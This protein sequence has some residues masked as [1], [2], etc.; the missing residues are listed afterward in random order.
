MLWDFQDEQ[1]VLDGCEGDPA[2]IAR[3]LLDLFDRWPPPGGAWFVVYLLFNPAD[4]HRLWFSSAGAGCEVCDQL[5]KTYRRET[6]LLS[7]CSLG[8]SAAFAWQF[9]LLP[10]AKASVLELRHV[11]RAHAAPATVEVVFRP[12]EHGVAPGAL[13]VVTRSQPL[14]GDG[15][16][17][18][19]VAEAASPLIY[20]AHHVDRFQRGLRW[21]RP[22][23]YLTERWN[24]FRVGPHPAC[25]F[26]CEP[27]A[28]VWT[29]S[30]LAREGRWRV[31]RAG[32]GGRATVDEEQSLGDLLLRDEAVGVCV[33]G[34]A[35]SPP[36]TFGEQ[37]K[38]NFVPVYDLA[39]VSRLLPLGP[40]RGYGYVAEEVYRRDGNVRSCVRL[41]VDGRF[42]YLDG[43]G[44][45]YSIDS[46]EAE[47][48]QLEP[49]DPVGSGELSST[50]QPF[51]G[52]GSEA[53]SGFFCGQLV[54]DNPITRR[55]ASRDISVPLR[56]AFVA[57]HD[58]MG[59]RAR[60][61]SDDGF[62]F[63]VR[64][65]ESATPVWIKPG[66]SGRFRLHTGGDAGWKFDNS[67]V[68]FVVGT[69]RFRLDAKGGSD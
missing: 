1:F 16:R 32:D 10:T 11:S 36:P 49:G 42:L 19:A 26:V 13:H 44:R 27:L 12:L 23:L 60:L 53:L 59:A 34:R 2:L 45:V 35:L 61:V 31:R 3:G 51:A 41:S 40:A 22:A 47:P 55:L 64:S 4:E 8:S 18:L 58:E 50:W 24:Q 46:V 9:E 17:L 37:A 68:E 63:L 7:A 52:E 56:E 54:F 43:G 33:V 62:N 14:L 66:E 39:V 28:G 25:E 21:G 67:P 48:R 30:L 69:T 65:A 5:L 38:E 29:V 6:E 20:V 15:E 57:N